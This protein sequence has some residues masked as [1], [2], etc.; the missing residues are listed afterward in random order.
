MIERCKQALVKMALEPEW[1]AKFEPNSYGF[2]PGRSCHDAREAIFN[3]IRS[4]PKF[5][6]DADIKGA[7]DNICQEKLLE[8]LQTYP[9]LR[10]AVKAWLKAGVMD[11]GNFSP[12]ERGTPQGGVISP[13]LMNIALHGMEQAITEGY[14]KSHVEKPLLVRYAD[15]FVIFHSN[16]QEIEKVA[17]RVT[18]W[19]QEMGLS[20][21]PTK[22]RISHTLVPHQ[23]QVGLEFLGFDIRQF[24]VGKT[25][26]GKNTNRKAL[27]FKTLIKPSKE[28]VKRHTLAIKERLHKL[29]SAPQGQL[30]KELNPVI[31]GWAAYYKTSVAKETFSRCD[32]TL[33]AQLTRWAKARHP[34]K[35]TQWIVQKYWH[36][37]GERKHVF[38]IPEGAQLRMHAKTAIQRYTKVKGR[39]SPYDGNMF[40]WSQRLK[41]HPMMHETKARLMQKQQGRCYWCGLHFKDDD[42]LEVDHIDRN[43]DN[44]DISNKRLLHRHCH[45]ERHAK[46][47]ND[48]KLASAG[49]NNK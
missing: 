49:I 42:L 46:L 33:W 16:L 48:D 11:D 31:W 2:R 17:K 45:D 19:L 15:D 36:Q 37:V 24:H 3:I 8:K 38:S 30:I 39:A 7:F 25:H 35:S 43:R 5:V 20:L 34:D 4:K 14:L 32:G 22:T 9:H 47:V 41:K 13:L 44:N 28:A 6:F 29:R 18:E 23:G 27:G 12:T 40:Y 26:T 1:E 10:R 21:S